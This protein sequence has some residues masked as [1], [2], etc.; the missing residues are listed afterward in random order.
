MNRPRSV[1]W[2]LWLPLIL[3]ASPRFVQA[4]TMEQLISAAKSEKELFFVAGPTTFGGKKGL[5][6]S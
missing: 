1:A 4:E 5:A 6:E 3:I 2:I